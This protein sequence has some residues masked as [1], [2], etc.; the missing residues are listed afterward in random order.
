MAKSDHIV[1]IGNGIAG[2]TAARHVRKL[3]D[4]RITVISAETDY[5]FSRT[6]LMYVY[7]GHMKF[8]HLHPYE[9]AFWKENAI[10]L[11]R[12]RVTAI[13]AKTRTLILERQGMLS[14]DKLVL[15]TGSTPNKFGRPG[16]DLLGVQGFYSKQD[17]DSLEQWAPEHNSCPRAVLVGG[18]LIGIELA[19]MLRSRDIAVTF[20]VRESGY[21]NQVLP[22]GASKMVDDHIREHGVDLRLG[23]GLGTILGDAHGRVRAVT[24]EESGEEITCR[25]VGL[26]IGVSPNIG[27]LNG[28]G[29]RLGRGV[30]VNRFLT[31]DFPD[32]FAIGDCAQLQDPP[33]GRKS[34]EAVWYTGRMMGETVARTLCGDPTEYR[35]GHWFNSAKFFDIEYQAYGQVS[36]E[37][38]N[39]QN[40]GQLH[41]RHPHKNISL[42]LAYVKSTRRFLGL[43]A[44]GLRMRHVVVDQWLRE[45]RC[46]ENVVAQ[47]AHAHFDPEFYQRYE[48]QIQQQF[49][50][51]L[52][53]TINR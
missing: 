36:G 27:F 50:S 51:E 12:D 14:Y 15:A 52:G 49:E 24:V 2:I 18:G 17:L 22:R 39:D 11:I 45:E 23:T 34:I 8:D 3:S 38:V 20:L 1:I 13:D 19:E 9:V 5:F 29:L 28:S 46:V 16:E 31:T 48:P 37:T 4:H 21:W 44:M 25:F 43:V 42:T 53:N 30:M 33:P 26:T 6:A 40:E 10:D 32:I 47:L 7:M 35:P 41:W